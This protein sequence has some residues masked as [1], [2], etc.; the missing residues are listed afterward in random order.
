MLVGIFLAVFWLSGTSPVARLVV[1][2]LETA[3]PQPELGALEA[4]GIKRVVVLTGGGYLRLGGLAA[5]A[6]PHASS[7]RFL[8]ALELCVRLGPD[9]ELVMTGS[10]GTN[11]EAIQTAD[12]MSELA[13]TLAPQVALQSESHSNTTAEHP[14]NV[15]PFVGGAPFALVTSA[16]HMPRAMLVFQRAGL[17]AI[18]YPV[19]YYTHPGIDGSDLVPDV[20]NWEAIGL[21]LH[22]YAGLVAYSLAR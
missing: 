21:A 5:G 22:E 6:L 4:A 12:V 7:L 11:H 2:P 20:H 9:C 1:A 16:Y 13:H 15:R 3:Y 10:A 17:D 14:E 8:S 18:P 19:D